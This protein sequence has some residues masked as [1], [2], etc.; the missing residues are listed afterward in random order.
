[1]GV[2]NLPYTATGLALHRDEG[3]ICA[4]PRDG[5]KLVRIDDTGKVGTVLEKDTSLVHPVDVGVGGK[6][7]T[8]VVAD[9]IAHTISVTTASGQKPQLYQKLDDETSSVN[10][11]MSLAVTTDKHVIYGTNG[12]AG[13]YR[14]NG[15]ESAGLQK[16]ILPGSG[17]VAADPG[18][19]KWAATQAPSQ[20]CVF[21]GEELVKKY[22]LPPN[23][24]IYRQGLLSFAP[25]GAVVVATRP[26]DNPAE[27]VWLIKYDTKN[28][29]D[30]VQ[31]LFP[32]KKDRLV[33][34]V[35]GPRM[36]WDRKSPNI[37]RSIY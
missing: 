33:D 36:L 2:V 34:F 16:P 18:S 17:G 30:E 1:L 14:L 5:G 19:L 8:I 26:S 15:D 37:Q 4:M 12:K 32:W 6:S 21:E 9:D 3:L 31:S 7:D 10:T 25:G 35:V 13:I 20:V 24:S 11:D 28:D 29:R 22:R 23:K 27:G